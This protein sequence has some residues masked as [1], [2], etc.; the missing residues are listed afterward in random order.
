MGIF[1]WSQCILIDVSGRHPYSDKIRLPVLTSMLLLTSR[2]FLPK[3]YT[4]IRLE[5]NTLKFF[6]V[7]LR[8]LF[9]FLLLISAILIR[10]SFLLNPFP[11]LDGKMVWRSLNLYFFRK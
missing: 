9:A 10:C 8:I 2:L 3:I 6:S 5:S 4:L 1:V 7:V 11:F